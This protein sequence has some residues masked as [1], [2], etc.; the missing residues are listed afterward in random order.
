[1][2]HKTTLST[3]ILTTTAGVAY[4]AFAQGDAVAT[5]QSQLQQPQ[6]AQ[7]LS[8]TAARLFQQELNRHQQENLPLMAAHVS[9]LDGSYPDGAVNLDEYGQVIADKDLHRLFD[10]YLSAR[11]EMSLEDIKH[12]LLSVSS[13]F[14]SLN[15]L[16]QVRDL[17]DQYVAYL[18]ETENFA[19]SM[20]PDLSLKERLMAVEAHR[21]QMLGKSL[22]DAFFAQ[23][24]AYAHWVMAMDAGEE[25]ELTPQ[26]THWLAQEEAAT[27]YQDVWLEQ[28]NMKAAGLSEQHKLNHWQDNYGAE[29]AQRLHRLDQQQTQ[30]QHQVNNYIA[31]RQG[32]QGDQQAIARLDSQFDERTLKRLHAWFANHLK[33]G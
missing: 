33:Q 22:S 32:L 10:H 1:M 25:L 15:Q 26:Q 8:V 20:A 23:E 7:P 9:S 12:R 31:E 3:I 24:H 17:F 13:D 5:Q 6:M 21:E 11:G 28:K 27:A 2:K 29:A 18:A 19:S 16:E 30:W 4:W 14:L